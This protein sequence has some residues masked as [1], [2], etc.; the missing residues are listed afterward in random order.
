MSEF[1]EVLVG[2]RAG[3]LHLMPLGRAVSGKTKQ[4]E[5]VTSSLGFNNSL[6]LLPKVS[7]MLLH[8]GLSSKGGWRILH[9]E[10]PAI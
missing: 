2:Q 8:S 7:F 9:L 4:N 6:P 1:T 10:H 5:A 3:I